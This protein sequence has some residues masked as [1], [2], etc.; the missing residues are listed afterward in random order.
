LRRFL[1]LALAAVAVGCGG[2]G[3][4]NPSA[5]EL[6]IP[7]NRVVA[8]SEEEGHRVI[9]SFARDGS[10]RTRHAALAADVEVR[11]VSPDGRHLLVTR[12]TDDQGEELY[13]TDLDGVGHAR[14]L[15]DGEMANIGSA[16]FSEDGR[17][18]LYTG[19]VGE[20]L[21]LVEMDLATGERTQ[22]EDLALQADY[23]G[24]GRIAFHGFDVEELSPYLGLLDPEGEA[25]A[26]VPQFRIEEMDAAGE[27]IVATERYA[28]DEE[29]LTRVVFVPANG[30][31]LRLL[32]GL[33]GVYDDPRLSPDG[34][35]AYVLHKTVGLVSVPITGG[36]ETVLAADPTIV[37]VL[38]VR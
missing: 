23:L 16:R 38:A 6:P 29:P 24:D 20:G 22:I 19:F 25:E 11:D 10:N 26:L 9:V 32:G 34:T 7:A 15:T 30:G 2:N 14:E 18:V 12:V 21:L 27:S 28:S 37:G 3:G 8:L 4:R 31:P 33:G 1:A 5:A 17:R 36:D 35:M 13:L